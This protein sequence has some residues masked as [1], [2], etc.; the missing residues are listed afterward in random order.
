MKLLNFFQWLLNSSFEKEK[1]EL[2]PPIAK[3]LH[4]H[5]ETYQ[6]SAG[7]LK[8]KNSPV[9]NFAGILFVTYII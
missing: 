5:L 6:L 8:E 1:T 3:L 4:L 7:L 2:K 9:T